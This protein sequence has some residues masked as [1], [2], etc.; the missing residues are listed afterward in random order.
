M[1]ALVRLYLTRLSKICLLRT[2]KT[3]TWHRLAI[4]TII[5]SEEIMRMV[6]SELNGVEIDCY[7]DFKKNYFKTSSSSF[8]EKPTRTG[9]LEPLITSEAV[10]LRRSACKVSCITRFK[11]VCWFV[12]LSCYTKWA[13]VTQNKKQETLYHN[14]NEAQT[15]FRQPNKPW[16]KVR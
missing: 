6:E 3:R 15:C 11:Y 12:L 9:N 1:L 7:T 4:T 5:M 10:L 14:G 2:Y 8:L 16:H 13:S